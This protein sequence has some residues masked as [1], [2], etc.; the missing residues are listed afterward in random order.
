LVI[1]ECRGMTESRNWIF[2]L[3]AGVATDFL[4]FSDVDIIDLSKGFINDLDEALLCGELPKKEH[5]RVSIGDCSEVGI[6]KQSANIASNHSN[7]REM[8][9]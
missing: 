8:V 2:L 3:A 9:P 5:L 6:V 4:H 7:S 1:G